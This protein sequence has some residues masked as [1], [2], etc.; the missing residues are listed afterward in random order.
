MERRKQFLIETHPSGDPKGRFSKQEGVACESA[1]WSPG[2]GSPFGRHLLLTSEALPRD[3]RACFTDWLKGMPLT[4]TP[5]HS[6]WLTKWPVPLIT[7]LDHS[8][9]LNGH[10]RTLSLV[11]TA[12]SW[13]SSPAKTC[14]EAPSV[15]TSEAH[16]QHPRSSWGWRQVCWVLL[17][18]LQ[19]SF[20]VSSIQTQLSNYFY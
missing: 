9:T 4:E 17:N 12:A 5:C 8:N 6:H 11:L 14:N 3:L 13:D 2:A 15:A 20:Y 10:T 16:K 1:F 7:T 18:H 19:N